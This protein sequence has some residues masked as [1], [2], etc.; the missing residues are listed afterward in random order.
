MKTNEI[1]CLLIRKI[2]SYIKMTNSYL[3]I[4]W[5]CTDVWGQPPVTPAHSALCWVHC[6]RSVLLRFLKS[7]DLS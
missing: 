5:H 3:R 1:F 6:A 7:L 2:M 4:P